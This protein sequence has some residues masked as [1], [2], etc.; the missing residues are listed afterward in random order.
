MIPTPSGR[1]YLLPVA[2]VMRLYKQHG[3]ERAASV[4]ASPEGLDVTASRT[5]DR[6][7]LHVVN[8]RRGQSITAQ[9]EVPGFSIAS[10]RCFEIAAD[11]Q[12]EVLETCPDVLQIEEKPLA[13]S[14]W[15]F[16]AA[17]V[18]AIELE[19]ISMEPRPK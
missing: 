17:S 9:L 14:D 18:S 5:A 4:L 13:G 7:F 19:L 8:T 12:I 16:P 1:S 6:L 2:H 3:G 10:G 15:S 11:P